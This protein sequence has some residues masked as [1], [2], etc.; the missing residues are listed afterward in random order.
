MSPE[1]HLAITAVIC[2][3]NRKAFL[4][5]C[6]DS[7]LNQTLPR[8]KYEILVIDN[9]STD[10]T[11]DV[12]KTYEIQHGV[13]WIYEPVIGLSRA[14]NTA[15]K[16]ARTNYMGY[17]D[18]DAVA[19]KCWLE[20]ALNCFLQVKPAPVW[21]GG[22]IHLEWETA[23]AS[24]I[25]EELSQPLGKLYWGDEPRFLAQSERLG[26][27]N[28]FYAVSFLSKIGGFNEK[29]GR[30]DVLLS[31]EETELQKR[32]QAMG[33]ALYY[34][35]KISIHHFVPMDR[36]QPS[37]FYRR[38]FWGGISDYIQKRGGVS[39]SCSK[40]AENNGFAIQ[41]GEKNRIL[42]LV[43]NAMDAFG[44]TP[45]A[46][47]VIQARIYWSYVFGW[48]AGPVYIVWQRDKP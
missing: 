41:Y 11:R 23:R 25:N 45:N 43:A 36:M 16:H 30:K 38:Y 10:G 21:I 27:G 8:E 19:E 28:S 46:D 24:W 9:G 39:N 12:L 20:K 5:K 1:M 44:S 14:R 26:G 13:R 32:A 15:W 6:L 34:H 2:T 48:L 3:R 35:P 22:A 47:S 18:D 7:L 17:I 42:R 31:G 29:L 40:D 4:V 37:W 33:H